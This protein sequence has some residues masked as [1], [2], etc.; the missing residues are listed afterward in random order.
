M[1]H[2]KLTYSKSGGNLTLHPSRAGRT[3]NI[4]SG[5][6]IIEVK[7]STGERILIEAIPRTCCAFAKSG[8]LMRLK[9]KD[10]ETA[11]LKLRADL[12][13]AFAPGVSERLRLLWRAESQSGATDPTP[14]DPDDENAW[15]VKIV[16]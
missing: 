14:L 11:V 8:Q 15:Q 16:S 7:N 2:L 13:Y 12:P 6:T 3:F 5:I 9:I 1:A 10:R 4:S